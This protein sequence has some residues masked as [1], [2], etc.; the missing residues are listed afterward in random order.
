MLAFFGAD[1]AEG[2]SRSPEQGPRP[3]GGRWARGRRRPWRRWRWSPSDR[4]EGR[5]W[6]RSGRG[7]WRGGE[8]AEGAARSGVLIFPRREWRGGRGRPTGA[9]RSASPVARWKATEW[10]WAQVGGGWAVW[11]GLVGAEASWAVAQWGISFCFCLFVFFFFSFYLFFP[12]VFI[13]VPHY[14]Y[15]VKYDNSS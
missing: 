15:L 13:L 6:G 9:P 4:E 14:F 11:T 3:R 5:V 1:E 2:R 8:E 7:K 12:S 10:G